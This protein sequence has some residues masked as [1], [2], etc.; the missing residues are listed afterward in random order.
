M[1]EGSAST[2]SGFSS[3][4]LPLWFVKRTENVTVGS[5]GVRWAPEG[6]GEEEVQT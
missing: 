3:S 5:K 4:L 1:R 6:R 2:Q